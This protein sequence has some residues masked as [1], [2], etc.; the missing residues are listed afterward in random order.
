[1]SDTQPPKPPGQDGG[2]GISMLS[3]KQ[4]IDELKREVQ[5]IKDFINDLN[6]PGRT[7]KPGL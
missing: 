1:M 6:D 3:L 4:E 5:R 2:G 7:G